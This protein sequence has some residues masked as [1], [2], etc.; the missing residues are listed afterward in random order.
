MKKSVGEVRPF[1]GMAQYFSRFIANYAT[2]AEPLRQQ[3]HLNTDCT[4]GQ[5]EHHADD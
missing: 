3:A 1:L 2:I 5:R 4:W